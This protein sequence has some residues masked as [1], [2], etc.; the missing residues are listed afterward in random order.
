[1]ADDAV[2]DLVDARFLSNTAKD[3]GGAVHA[4][5]PQD[6][7]V[8]FGLL[9]RI[10]SSLFAGNSARVGGG[11]YFFIDIDL[12]GEGQTED[13]FMV[14]AS[15]NFTDNKAND[16]GGAL[17]TNAPDSLDVLCN[18]D[19]VTEISEGNPD[20]G[21]RPTVVRAN[22]QP[23][24][25]VNNRTS[26]CK[27]TWLGNEAARADGRDLV[28]TAAIFVE[29]C[30]EASESCPSGDEGLHIA[31]HTSGLELEPITVELIEASGSPAF[32]QPPM[33]LR[34]SSD[35]GD[36]VLRGNTLRDVEPTMNITN[37]R[38]Q[39]RVNKTHRL[40]LSFEP[41]LLPNVSVSVDVRRC[42]A[43]EI[44]IDGGERCGECPDGQY[45]FDPSEDCML[46]PDRAVCSPST[47]T[48]EESYWHSTSKSTQ[49]HPCIVQKACRD[50]KRQSV[51]QE[52]A[53]EVHSNG[54]LL[55]YE[56]NGLYPLCFQGHAGILCGACDKDHGKVRSGE[57]IECTSETWSI[58][59]TI[60][61][62]IWKLLES[63]V[64]IASARP[65]ENDGSHKGAPRTR[66]KSGSAH[67]A[68]RSSSNVGD[69][70]STI[71]DGLMQELPMLLGAQVE[72]AHMDDSEERIGSTRSHVP[73]I[74]KVILNF[75]QVTGVAVFISADW[76]A[77]VLWMLV[78]SDTLA[79][80]SE[81]F[82]SLECALPLGGSV[83]RSVSSTILKLLFP[84]AAILFFMSLF[85]I[86][87]WWKT[88]SREHVRRNWSVSAMAVLYVS[89]IQMAR[90]VVKILDCTDAD[91]G[92][93]GA[94]EH[95]VALAKY[96]T[97]DTDV[98]C[99]EGS[100][101]GI[102]LGLA[103]PLLF[104]VIAGMPLFL[105]LLAKWRQGGGSGEGK[106]L[107]S[108]DFLTKS[109]KEKFQYWEVFVLLRKASLAVITVFSYS[110][111]PNLQVTL[112]LVVM[113]ISISGQLLVMPFVTDKLNW[114][115]TASLVG[116]SVAFFAG[117]VFNDPNT[118]DGGAIAVSV[119]L[120][121]SFVGVLAY[122]LSELIRELWKL[123]VKAVDRIVEKDRIAVSSSDS[124]M[125]KLTLVVSFKLQ[126]A[127]KQI[128]GLPA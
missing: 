2:V 24:R 108:Y 81:G 98:E 72:S 121:L 77:F 16:T 112:A 60:G 7:L 114:M 94:P 36:A 58:S 26:L 120:I 34:I 106:L 48:P 25:S 47:I 56:D 20:R 96:W 67:K 52:R 126:A 88:Q 104:F 102:F 109:Y 78:A 44:P 73:D 38:L 65:K 110:L 31:N 9:A 28:A 14:I 22:R 43:G 69:T 6:T 92:E 95:A 3:L 123:L 40:T 116:S 111:G 8:A 93:I 27:E 119:C 103:V 99:F 45:S 53:R 50:E 63:A 19:F 32:G 46:C 64:V 37:I 83:N 74:M 18:S 82:F 13:N 97:E 128:S 71:N 12:E 61:I 117:L 33:L 100:H 21:L 91:R 107:E 89:Y 122:L 4:T 75:L 113:F 49:V 51:L 29:A 86:K 84:F 90:N 23:S 59:A 30:R 42:L 76:S 80:G 127:F 55:D 118:S 68:S 17:F 11:L 62:A 39:A 87:A 70:G 115:E 101:L 57:C 1:M 125:K 124:T 105:F 15:S 41:G 10:Q 54:A 79:S 5:S 35:G 85:S 66:S